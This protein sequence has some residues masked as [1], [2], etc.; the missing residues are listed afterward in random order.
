MRQS[1]E[2]L[3]GSQWEDVFF[4]A[5]EPAIEKA[6]KDFRRA[7]DEEMLRRKEQG[8]SYFEQVGKDWVYREKKQVDYAALK[9]KSEAFIAEVMR[10]KSEGKWERDT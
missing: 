7:E 4:R 10:L 9:A 8:L 6:L 2:F 1:I 5:H 3:R